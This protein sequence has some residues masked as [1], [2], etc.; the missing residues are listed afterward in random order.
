MEEQ[1]ENMMVWRCGDLIA[2]GVS[3]A[4]WGMWGFDNMGVVFLFTGKYDKI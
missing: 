1:K 4:S 2:K 3:L